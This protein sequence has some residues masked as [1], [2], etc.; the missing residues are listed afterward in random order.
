[1]A[2]K[3][4]KSLGPENTSEIIRVTKKDSGF[5]YI[6]NKLSK[7]GEDG[8]DKKTEIRML[9]FVD[10][11]TGEIFDPLHPQGNPNNIRDSL[12]V[13][14]IRAELLQFFKSGMHTF[15][16][17]VYEEDKE[18]N[19]IKE[20]TPWYVFMNRMRFK[21]AEITNQLKQGGKIE[22]GIEHWGRFRES[23]FA[24]PQYLYFIQV[25]AKRINGEVKKS[26]G[27]ITPIGP[28]VF[29]IP[30]Y[31]QTRT[32]F[33]ND[34]LSVDDEDEGRVE[35]SPQTCKLGDFYTL[36]HGR[37]LR[38][39][40]LDQEG[41]TSYAME[42]SKKEWP[43]KV[44]DL[45]KLTAPWEEVLAIQYVEDQLAEIKK[46]ME[47]KMLAYAFRNSM[48]APYINKMGIDIDIAKEII[49]AE[50]PIVTGK[51]VRSNAEI[52][53]YFKKVG[54]SQTVKTENKTA[55]VSQD[56]NDA[57]D[58]NMDELNSNVNM[59]DDDG[60]VDRYQENM[61]Q[62]NELNLED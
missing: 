12:G 56:I 57:V 1:M 50:V 16:T 40:R 43:L 44:E 10:A 25:L 54:S 53:E 3:P 6:P 48:Y 30:R 11:D 28:G 15:L 39:S 22:P 18:G 29:A 47:P 23:N 26:N 52:N 9:P 32:T 21:I 5:K 51:R 2:W 33:F 19:P 59:D 38:M 14:F 4:A 55:E 24:R 42:L 8:K 27:K 61:G 31:I 37:P 20:S 17:S 7:P 46:L 41:N 60:S 62:L 49:E 58:V 34:M 45:P 13:A 36:E 35:L